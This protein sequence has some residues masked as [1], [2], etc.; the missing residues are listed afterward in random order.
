MDALAFGCNLDHR[1]SEEVAANPDS[2][3]SQG[4]LADGRGVNMEVENSVVTLDAAV[5]GKEADFGFGT[6]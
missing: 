3:Y 4:L 2:A 5:I 1:G 6:G